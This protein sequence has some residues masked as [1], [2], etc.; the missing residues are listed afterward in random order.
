MEFDKKQ[1]WQQISQR[2]AHKTAQ[3]KKRARSLF[4]AAAIVCLSVGYIAYHSFFIQQ[5][6]QLIEVTT[7]S[8]ET[9]TVRLS[10]GST[11]VLN[12]NSSLR[13][14]EPLDKDLRKV[15]L[16]HGEATFDIAKD[17]KRPFRVAVE[18]AEIEVLG[19][20]FNVNAYS[21][22][23]AVTLAEGSIRFKKGT[24]QCMLVPGERLSFDPASQKASREQ[25]DTLAVLDWRNG[26]WVFQQMPLDEVLA[27]LAA[28]Y[29]L[30]FVNARPD[31]QYPLITIYQDKA[32]MSL[33]QLL[34]LLQRMGKSTIQFDQKS[35][36]L[37]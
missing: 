18:Q 14:A 12:T 8:K 27:Q 9:K 37:K 11:L 1:A 24:F 29:N 30:S 28:Q 2:I 36:L 13:Y 4:A 6:E 31:K 33:P 3:R 34:A 25:L 20:L 26:K 16:L 7:S 23:L 15:E 22:K 21:S 32:G 5:P 35:I 10:D 17:A 19:T